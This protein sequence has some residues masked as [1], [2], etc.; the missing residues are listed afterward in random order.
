M[1]DDSDSPRELAS[2]EAEPAAPQGET[3]A[4]DGSTTQALAAL[5]ST[6][7]V[8]VADES[9][10]TDGSSPLP[11]LVV[12]I[13]AS[14]GGVEAYIELFRSLAPDTG[15]AFVVVPHLLATQKSHLVDILQRFTSMPVE[16]IIDGTQPEPNHVYIIPPNTRVRIEKG[17]LRLDTRAVDR[18]PRPID[19]FFRSLGADQKSRAI[20][21]VLSGTDA[22]G[23]LGL[24]AIKGEGGVAIVQSP[25]SARFSEMPLSSISIDHVDRILPPGQI[26]TELARIAE[27]I[28]EPVLRTFEA[29]APPPTEEQQFYRI[30]NV[31]RGASGIDFRLYKPSTIRRRIARR[32]LLHPVRSMAE[33]ASLVQAD[34][35]ELQELLEDALIDVTRFFRDSSVFEALKQSIFPNIFQHREPDQQVRIWVPGCSSGE[36]AYSI[37]MVLLEYLSGKSFEPPVQIFATDASETNIQKARAGIFPE[38]IVSEVSPE[39]LWRFFVKIDKG[40]QVAKRVRDICIF[41]RQNLCQDPPFSKMDLISCRNVLIYMGTDLQKQVLP[42][43]HYSLRQNGYLLLGTSETIREFTDLFQLI[44]RKNKFFAK[45]GNGSSRMIMAIAPWLFVPDVAQQAAPRPMLENWGELELQRAADRIVLARYGP[46]GVVVD[47]RLEILQ[48][49][50]HTAPFLEMAHGSVSLQLPRMLRES[51]AAPVTQAVRRAVEQDIPVRI[52]GLRV[53]EDDQE[54]NTAVDILPIHTMAPRSRCFLV[55]FTPRSAEAVQAAAPEREISEPEPESSDAELVRQDL[56]TTKLYLQTLIEE[57]DAKNQELL[58][59]NE[60]IQS[61]NEEMQSTNEEL[62]TTKEE[63]QSSNEELQT[64]NDE[65]QQRN[66]SLTQTTNDLANLLNSVNLPVLMLSS[67]LTIRHFTPPT[68]RLMNLRAPDIGRPFSDIRLNLNIDNLEPILL[69]VL[70]TLAPREIDVQDREGRWY[71]LRVRPYRTS[72]NKIDGVVVVLLDVDQLR[73]IQQ[74]LRDARDFAASVIENIPLPLA[75]VDLDLRIHAVND[76]FRELAGLGTEDLER[77]FLRDVASVAWGL[78]EPLQSR[79]AELRNSLNI[80]DNFEF[81]FKAAGE[82]QREFNVHG[83]VLKPDSA[84]FL[85]VTFEDITA[86]AQVERMLSLERERLVSQVESTAR[87]LGRTQDE[88]RALAG[89]L[90]SSQEDERRRLARELHDDISQKLAVL[91]I[92]TQQLTQRFSPASGAN[93]ADANRELERVRNA[94]ASLSEDVRRISHGLHPSVIDDLGL[95]AGI[96]SLVEDFRERENM[97]GTFS[98]QNIPDHLPSGIAI[99][100]Y[101]ITQEALRNV[102]KHAGKTHVKV[103]LK[104]EGKM[105]RLQVVDSGEGFDLQ[106]RR[107]GLGLISM[108]ERARMMEGTFTIESDLGEGTR[109][110]VDVPRPQPD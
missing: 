71:L 104:G 33:Y 89:S 70:E 10:E 66:T 52:E 91:E 23:A 88:L 72:D 3:T 12:G 102:A 81:Q 1:T 93:I 11:Y 41:A 34:P 80:G 21:V 14:A 99:G 107:S 69:Q 101:R 85:L 31:M 64:V 74:E 38:S 19:Y 61:A 20:G 56:S 49:R 62:E 46:S 63:L 47:E 82:N 43:F 48:C 94:I 24:K 29:G 7:P 55:L 77:R 79:L 110:T 9:E 57:R 26:A 87:E 68:Q 92:E 73:R 13:G 53:R 8:V 25:E 59:A 17:I 60:E 95:A 22:D 103:I 100:L 42:I 35:K 5:T 6:E 50:G 96:R 78:E 67:D 28:Q 2:S 40:Y 109:I 54:F 37:A 4:A 83:R 30:L 39:R 106:Q 84:T 65:L 27:R 75:V 36:E 97:I 90:F 51:I 98:A 108:E 15:M 86:H 76:A 58:S 45:I 44:D 32:M 18:V 105:M 16:E